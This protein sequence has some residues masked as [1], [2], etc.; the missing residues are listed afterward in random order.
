MFLVKDDDELAMHIRP[1]EQRMRNW[2]SKCAESVFLKRS[3]AFWKHAVTTLCLVHAKFVFIP[4]QSSPPSAS[5]FCI[6]GRVSFSI[7]REEL[8]E[9][10]FGK[11]KS[12]C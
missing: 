9:L 1:D 10:N 12:C 11:K 3:D 4:P 2:A 8:Q 6:F 5:G 7:S